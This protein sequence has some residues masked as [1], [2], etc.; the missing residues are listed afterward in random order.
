MEKPQHEMTKRQLSHWQKENRLQR[1]VILGG[2]VLIVAILAVIGTGLYLNKYKPLNATVIKVGDTEYNMNYFINTLSDYGIQNVNSS[3]ASYYASYLV[4]T[5]EQNQ[6]LVEEATK[7]DPPI[8]VSDDEIDQYLTDNELSN[9]TTRRDEVRAQLMM[10]K[11]KSDYFGSTTEPTTEA[12]KADWVPLTAEQKSVWAM[13]LESQSQVDTVKARLNSGENFSDIAAE[14]SLDSTSKDNKGDFGWVPKGILTNQLG[15]TSGTLLENAIFGSDST[16]SPIVENEL[17]AV[18]DTDVSKSIGYWLLEVTEND[19]SNNQ[20]HLLAMLL[21]SQEQAEQ[22]KAKLEAG[23]EGNDWAT[24]AKANSIYENAAT[25]GGDLG[26]VAKGTIDDVV[27]AIIFPE[28]AT[29]ALPLNQISGAIA[30][31]TQTTTGGYW[32]VQV[33]GTDNNMTISDANRTTLVSTKLNSWFEEKWT[34][35]KD[36]MQ[37][38]LTND[39]ITYAI[40]QAQKR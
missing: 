24:L 2:I 35:Q 29:Q 31:T 25:D 11:L 8:T 15:D 38:L 20:V 30:D 1:I 13:L 26:F 9:T 16:A 5:I 27:D 28:D 32:L 7:L 39:Q 3:Y 4:Q 37:N 21:S 23:G 33:N 18:Q 19:T 14:L 12:W 6:I 22:I 10:E 40:E 36:N 34:A 17:T